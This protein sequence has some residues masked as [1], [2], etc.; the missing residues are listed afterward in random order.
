MSKFT[1]I[2]T[3][4]EF[5]KRANQK[6]SNLYDYSLVSFPKR[7]P[8]KVRVGLRGGGIKETFRKAVEYYGQAYVIIK[9][10]QHGNFSQR[11]RKHLEGHGCPK[12][13][14][15][16]T[17][18]INRGRESTIEHKKKFYNGSLSL[19]DEVRQRIIK[20]IDERKKAK[21]ECSTKSLFVKYKGTKYEILVDEE[22]Y[23]LVSQY[24]WNLTRTRHRQRDGGGE[25]FYVNTTIPRPDKPRYLYTYPNGKQRTYMAKDTLSIHRLIM[26][27]EKGQ[28]VD[29]INGNTFDNRKHN[30]RC[31]SYEQNSA[32]SIG[33]RKSK[34]KYKGVSINPWGHTSYIKKDGKTI[35]LGTYATEEEAARAY[36]IA[37]LEMHGEFSYINF[38]IENYLYEENEE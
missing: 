27:P 35:N 19:S 31:C 37:S 14:N 6:H 4:A 33:K 34:S 22:D 32:N 9:C 7:A 28:V 16:K 20:S 2:K 21:N 25:R 23:Q 3:K 5:I 24:R 8:M 17:A 36:D 10:M 18:A 29:H 1:H 38:P 13:A 12:C 30:L 15:E 26:N 11:A